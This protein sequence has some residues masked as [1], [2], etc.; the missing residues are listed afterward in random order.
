MDAIIQNFED[1]NRKLDMK[2][3][4]YESTRNDYQKEQLIGNMRTI[5]TSMDKTVKE[6][7]SE[8]NNMSISE[9]GPYR[10]KI[11]ESRKEYDIKKRKINRYEEENTRNLNKQRLRNGELR[12]EEARKAERDMVID[13]HKETDYQGDL[14]KDIHKDVKEMNQNLDAVNV[15]V[16]EQGQQIDRIHENVINSNQV[17]KKTD[18]VIRE[19]SRRNFCV[20]LLLNGAVVLAGILIVVLI[21]MNIIKKFRS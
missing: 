4:E 12:G 3:R 8:I 21:V 2:I 11:K 14:I 19:M 17:V 15:A 10:S 18:N 9:Q 7:E 5:L 16:D 1:S 13:I 6:A 20:K